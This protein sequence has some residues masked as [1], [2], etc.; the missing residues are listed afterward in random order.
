MAAAVRAC[1]E[2]SSNFSP[3]SR[4]FAFEQ[5]VNNKVSVL[6]GNSRVESK[7]ARVRR[8]LLEMKSIKSDL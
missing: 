1:Y 7:T 2:N 4:V 5:L 6:L 3:Q 8:K